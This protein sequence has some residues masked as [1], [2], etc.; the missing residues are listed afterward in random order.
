MHERKAK[1]AELADAFAALPGGIGTLEELLEVTTWNKLG[2]H[3]KPCGVL[4]VEGY[5]DKFGAMLDKVVDEEFMSPA[6]RSILVFDDDPA[7][8]LDRLQTWPASAAD[9]R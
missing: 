6:D 1:M 2:I 3:A 7:R 9:G 8:L 4:N 5:Y